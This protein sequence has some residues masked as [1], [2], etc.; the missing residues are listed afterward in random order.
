MLTIYMNIT[1]K[2]RNSFINIIIVDFNTIEKTIGYIEDCIA[3]MCGCDFGFTIVDNSESHESL[4]YIL[5]TFEVAKEDVIDGKI[6]KTFHLRGKIVNYIYNGINV[7]YARGNNLG[8][9]I[10]KMLY[11]FDYFII[12][13]NDLILPDKFDLTY[14]VS[15]FKEHHE[16]GVIGPEIIGLQNES[17]SPYKRRSI[18]QTIIIYSLIWPLNK[19]LNRLDDYCSDLDMNKNNHMCYWVQGSF[20]VV[21]SEA[22]E[23]AG[24]FDE[25]TFLYCEEMILAER[26]DAISKGMYFDNRY[27]IIHNHGESTKKYYDF[28]GRERLAFKSKLYYFEHYRHTHRLTI[29]F[30]KVCFEIYLVKKQIQFK[31]K[32]WKSI[33][34]K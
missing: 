33:I 11:D 17:Q 26:L 10:S 4:D 9:N 1:E 22:F 32:T 19:L 25:N 7:G 8:F 29:I 14:Y 5:N 34:L 6:V 27:K 16:I 24:M 2:E 15:C 30:A 3:K 13:N 20:L 23:S 12:S 21:N 28:F 18:W 31:V